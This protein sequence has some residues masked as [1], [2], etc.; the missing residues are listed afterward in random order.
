MPRLF[1]TDGVRGVANK[2]LLPELAFKLGRAVGFLAVE[3]GK[4]KVLVGRDPRISGEMLS[5]ALTAGLT[6]AG[7]DCLDLGIIPT[8]AV[9]L[10]CR[11]MEADFGAVISASHNPYDDNGIKFFDKNGM[12]L[13]EEDEERIAAYVVDDSGQFVADELPRPVGNKVGRVYSVSDAK[14]RYADFL[15][16]TADFSLDGYKIVVDCANGATSEVAPKV[17]ESLGAKVIL[18]NA[19]P[20][21]VNINRSCGS[22][23]PEQLQEAV[24]RSGAHAGIAHDGDGDRVIFVDEQGAIVDGDKQLAITAIDLLKN[25]ML[26]NNA[27]AAT[28]YSN[29]GLKDCLS[30]FGGT[31]YFTEN[32]DRNVLREMIDRGLI[33]GGEQS[34]HIIHAN[35][36]LTG[37]GILSA[38]RLLEIMVRS[39]APLS[40]LAAQMT[41]FPQLL[42]SV[43]VK[44]KKKIMTSEFVLEAIRKG[45]EEM[46]REGRLFVRP[47]GTEPVVRIMGE[48]KDI[49]VVRRIV[50][51]VATAVASADKA[52]DE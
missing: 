7:A 9:A 20:D 36:N 27:I 35:Y 45:Q 14:D 48:A 10:I 44:D 5:A 47:S 43:K 24:V 15:L 52:E 32:G 23:H 28:V 41:P 18:I 49:T 42:V 13:S 2:E 37:D 46:G 50:N 39:K 3:E 12:K 21:G 6:S 22:T 51:E 26:P 19:D 31:V 11:Q 1:G 40:E 29:L 17:Y 16:S 4:G 8:P 38:I 34:G 30:S 25:N 33:L